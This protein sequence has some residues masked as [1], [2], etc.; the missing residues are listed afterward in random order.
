MDLDEI[1]KLAQACVDATQK[2]TSA[3]SAYERWE[4]AE[5]AK[6]LYE[7][8]GQCGEDILDLIA[9]LRTM[10]AK[11][12]VSRCDSVHFAERVIHEAQARGYRDG[13]R[14]AESPWQTMD[15]APLRTLVLT[16]IRHTNKSVHGPHTWHQIT[17]GVRTATDEWFDEHG[18]PMHTP[19]AWMP[20]PEPPK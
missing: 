7:D 14:A 10:E 15:T 4:A 8:L 12:V 20:L 16:S 17:L 1:E 13:L 2:I 11:G 19:V 6:A 5:A 18:S 3:S 9:R